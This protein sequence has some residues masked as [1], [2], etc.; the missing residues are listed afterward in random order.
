MSDTARMTE[1]EGPLWGLMACMA[2]GTMFW[3]VTGM[4]LLG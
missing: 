3:I 4:M 2:F 1:T